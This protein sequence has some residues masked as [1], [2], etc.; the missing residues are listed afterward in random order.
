IYAAASVRLCDAISP[1]SNRRSR[2]RS[3]VAFVDPERK[4]HLREPLRPL[5]RIVPGNLYVRSSLLPG[6]SSSAQ[7]NKIVKS[8]CPLGIVSEIVPSLALNRKELALK[9]LPSIRTFVGVLRTNS[10]I[11]AGVSALQD[12][13]ASFSLTLPAILICEVL[14]NTVCSPCRNQRAF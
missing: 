1:N 4:A 9:S 8:C 12:T 5:F 2:T 10:V 7:R 13:V 14:E 3:W 6:F 11:V